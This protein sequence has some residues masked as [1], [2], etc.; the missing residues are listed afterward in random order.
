MA[1]ALEEPGLGV[2]AGVPCWQVAPLS[3]PWQSCHGTVQREIEQEQLTRTQEV[4][5]ER[6]KCQSAPHGRPMRA[7][8]QPWVENSQN[9][10][11]RPSILKAHRLFFS[12]FPKQCSMTN[13]CSAFQLC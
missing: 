4:S 5:K 8:N 6:F 10:A 9:E 11:L 2:G 3:G 12:L 7:F 1:K 13:P